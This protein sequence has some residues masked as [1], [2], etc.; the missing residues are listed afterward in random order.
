MLGGVSPYHFRKR[1]RSRSAAARPRGRCITNSER[2]FVLVRL[3]RCR[4]F[5]R[6]CG[7]FAAGARLSIFI[8]RFCW[9][10]LPG[11]TRPAAEQLHSF[12]N[13]AK[14][15]S[16]MPSL[17]IVLGDRLVTAFDANRTSLIQ[18]LTSHLADP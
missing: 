10:A 12:A 8:G 15:F 9:T 3:G 14:P 13:D 16:F 5:R 2:N 7:W 1:P 4:G 6:N 18:I 11:A 17:Q